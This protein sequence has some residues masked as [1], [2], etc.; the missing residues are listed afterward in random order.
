MKM[1]KP[2]CA[3]VCYRAAQVVA[4]KIVNVCRKCDASEVVL[5]LG[6]NKRKTLLSVSG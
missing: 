2:K 3:K 1:N 4:G 5:E 6:E